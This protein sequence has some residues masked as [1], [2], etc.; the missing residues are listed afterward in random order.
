MFLP[1]NT[2]FIYQ[3]FALLYNLLLFPIGLQFALFSL[4]PGD[5]GVTSDAGCFPHYTPYTNWLGTVTSNTQQTIIQHGNIMSYIRNT[6]YHA[7]THTINNDTI[8][9]ILE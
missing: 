5:G 8:Q 3:L 7:S 1:I 2:G 9:L 4:K 6:Q